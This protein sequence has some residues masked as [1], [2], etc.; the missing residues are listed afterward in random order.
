MGQAEGLVLGEAHIVEGI[1][2]APSALG[3]SR[4]LRLRSHLAAIRDLIIVV[5]IGLPLINSVGRAVLDQH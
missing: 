2:S 4:A 1:T 5:I 3:V